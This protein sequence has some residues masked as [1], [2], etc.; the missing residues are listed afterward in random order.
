MAIVEFIVDYSNYFQT[1]LVK[2]I[3]INSSSLIDIH[4]VFLLYVNI[5]SYSTFNR[6]KYK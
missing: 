5:L 2:L 1:L 6:I 3:N 4:Y